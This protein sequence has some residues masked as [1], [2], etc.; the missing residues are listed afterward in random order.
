M[1]ELYTENGGSE[2]TREELNSIRNNC[3]NDD[4]VVEILFDKINDFESRTCE[5]CKEYI[6]E[7]TDIWTCKIGVCDDKF[8]ECNYVDKDFGCNNW[9]EKE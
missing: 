7:H 6:Q 9:E 1:I 8:F 5:N 3:K 4:C 2:M